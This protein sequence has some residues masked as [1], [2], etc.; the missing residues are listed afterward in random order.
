MKF[1]GCN[2]LCLWVV[3]SFQSS[4]CVVFLPARETCLSISFFVMSSPFFVFPFCSVIIWLV[5]EI[6]YI[7]ESGGCERHAVLCHYFS[8]VQ[9]FFVFPFSLSSLF[10][11]NMMAVRDLLSEW[12]ADRESLKNL[13]N[14]ENWV[15]GPENLKNPENRHKIL[16]RTLKN[17]KFHPPEKVKFILSNKATSNNFTDCQ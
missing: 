9:S 10:C 6:Y 12:I 13:K 1:D 7:V 16:L 8:D 17:K 3:G 15:S 2:L 11:H 14:P 5:W 4:N